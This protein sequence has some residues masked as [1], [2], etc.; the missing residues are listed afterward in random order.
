MSPLHAG[1]IGRVLLAY[2]LPEI[3]EEVIAHGLDPVTPK[4][5]DEVLLREA[6]AETRESG[7]A[8]SEGELVSGSVGIA[9]PIFRDGGIVGAVGIIGPEGRCGLA[10]RARVIH[11]LPEAARTIMAGLEA[12]A[13][14]PTP[15]I[16]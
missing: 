7:I 9:A 4:T 5:P 15:P 1:A 6:L 16:E 3:V 14:H 10:W 8:R 11:L 12:D 2:A 13:P